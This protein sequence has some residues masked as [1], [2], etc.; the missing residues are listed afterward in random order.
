MKDQ[1]GIITARKRCPAP[2]RAASSGLMP[3]SR[4]ILLNSTIRMAL[5][6]ERPMS[7]HACV[8]GGGVRIIRLFRHGC[9]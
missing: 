3:P 4:F 2:A 9:G 1:A 7:I 6:A 5:F 8:G